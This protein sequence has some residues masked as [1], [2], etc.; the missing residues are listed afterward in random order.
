MKT[1][2]RQD[3]KYFGPT[4]ADDRSSFQTPTTFLTSTCKRLHGEKKYRHWFGDTTEIPLPPGDY[5][6]KWKST[7]LTAINFYTVVDG[8]LAYLVTNEDS[9]ARFHPTR[10]GTLR[11]SGKV[12]AVT[13]EHPTYL[14]ITCTP[15][16]LRRSIYPTIYSGGHLSVTLPSAKRTTGHELKLYSARHSIPRQLRKYTTLPAAQDVAPLLEYFLGMGSVVTAT[17]R[18]PQQDACSPFAVKLEAGS[19]LRARL[20]YK[21]SVLTADEE[22]AITVTAIEGNT[23]STYMPIHDA[24]GQVVLA[25]HVGNTLEGSFD[26]PI[27]CQD[28]GL[29]FYTEYGFAGDTRVDKYH[30]YVTFHQYSITYQ[31]VE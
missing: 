4:P 5:L 2:S 13:T 15:T 24:T 9:Y 25:E 30:G 29:H 1:I 7:S 6:V 31:F 21:V 28:I 14:E 20:S 8:R 19:N 23:T 16:I 18:L 26:L 12:L 11:T 3:I 27:G 17:I 10:R 22:P